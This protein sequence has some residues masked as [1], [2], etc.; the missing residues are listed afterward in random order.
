MSIQT[1]ETGGGVAARYISTRRA[2]LTRSGR[3]QR[4]R[5]GTN[6]RFSNSDKCDWITNSWTSA[7]KETFDSV[8]PD[9]RQT[10]KPDISNNVG[11]VKLFLKTLLS[12]HL[13]E[14]FSFVSFFFFLLCID[15]HG[16]FVI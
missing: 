15:D 13:K 5:T 3:Q 14:F 12:F 9:N 1:S 8:G 6:S 2:P 11:P 16:S 7:R 10:G 4:T